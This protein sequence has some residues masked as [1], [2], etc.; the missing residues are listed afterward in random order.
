MYQRQPPEQ[1]G[2]LLKLLLLGRPLVNSAERTE[3]MSKRMALGVLSSD[4]VSSSAYGSEEM[5]RI[6]V[7]VVGVAAFTL[8]LPV[9]AVILVVLLLVTIGHAPWLTLRATTAPGEG[10]IGLGV[11]R[12]NL[13]AW[14]VGCWYGGPA[15]RVHPTVN[16]ALPRP[17]LVPSGTSSGQQASPNSLLIRQTRC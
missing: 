15:T 17:L 8:V 7:P 4:C 9:T 16:F 12:P 6:P 10:R 14:G 1:T 5:L 13:G 11:A 2:Y 3:R